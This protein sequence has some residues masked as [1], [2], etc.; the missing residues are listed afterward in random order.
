MGIGQTGAVADPEPR[1]RSDRSVT[2]VRLVSPVRQVGCAGVTGA[3]R[4]K[5]LTV[6]NNLCS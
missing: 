6:R 4:A 5:H 1:D 3:S 2:S